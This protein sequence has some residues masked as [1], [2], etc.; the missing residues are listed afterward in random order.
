M[1][2]CCDIGLVDVHAAQPT[3]TDERV[4]NAMSETP[5]YA[6]SRLVL[7]ISSEFGYM[8]ASIPLELT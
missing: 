7:K 8:H 5:H 4:G 6:G 3:N 2:A 1:L